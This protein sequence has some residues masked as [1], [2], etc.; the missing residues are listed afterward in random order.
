MTPTNA[1]RSKLP[2]DNIRRR[3]R[4]KGFVLLEVIISMT[5]LAATVAVVLRSFSQ[6]LAAARQ[7][8]ARTQAGFFARQLLDEFEINPPAEGVH[9]GGFGDDYREYSYVARV[10]YVEPDY[11]GLDVPQTIEEFYK[12]RELRIEIRFDDGRSA[13]ITAASVESAIMGFERFSEQARQQQAGAR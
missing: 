4:G 2:N 11:R 5:I 7:L 13:P 1:G 12:I 8:E 10:D 3:R 9:E 6:S